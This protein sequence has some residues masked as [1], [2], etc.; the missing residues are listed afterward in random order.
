MKLEFI[1]D[2]DVDT[3]L[4]RI[5]D[6]DQ[7]AVSRLHQ[8]IE[9]LEVGTSDQVFLHELPSMEC[10]GDCRLTLKVGEHDVGVRRDGSQF[11]CTL[12]RTGWADVASRVAW[13]QGESAG[14]DCWNELVEGDITLILSRFGGW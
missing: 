5:Y 10:V 11:V 6:F 14:G 9:A 4:I 7:A 2:G 1:P 13:F 3:P 8:A 12:T